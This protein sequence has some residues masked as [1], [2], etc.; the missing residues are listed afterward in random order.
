M[1]SRRSGNEEMGSKMARTSVALDEVTTPSKSERRSE[2]EDLDLVSHDSTLDSH[3][4]AAVDA[5]AACMPILPTSTLDPLS[6][7]TFAFAAYNQSSLDFLAFQPHQDGITTSP[8]QHG[9]HRLHQA[10]ILV[11]RLQRRCCSP[12]AGSALSRCSS[13]NYSPVLGDV[14]RRISGLDAAVL[15]LLWER[16]QGRGCCRRREGCALHRL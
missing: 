6:H 14:R 4:G 1:L 12:L 13:P 11:A 10:S 16:E 9:S 7:S 5:L 15:P 3:A 8:H 2:L